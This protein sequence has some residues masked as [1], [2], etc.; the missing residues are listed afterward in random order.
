[1]AWSQCAPVLVL[2]N[3]QYFL[4][5]INFD[6]TQ[7]RS[8]YCTKAMVKTISVTLSLCTV[9]GHLWTAVELVITTEAMTTRP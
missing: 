9:M 6:T 2:K 1:M 8:I 4:R 5:Q 7:G 3:S